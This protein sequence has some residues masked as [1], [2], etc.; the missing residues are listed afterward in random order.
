MDNQ[1]K[2][3]FGK[4]LVIKEDLKSGICYCQCKCGQYRSVP[5]AYLTAKVITSCGCSKARAIDLTGQRFGSLTAIQPVQMRDTDNSV[6]WLC[7]CSC[8]S[9]TTVSS[10]KLRTNHT[11]SCGCQ[12]LSLIKA[13]KTFIDGTCVEVLLSNKIR[14]NNTSGHTGVAKKGKKWQAYLTYGKKQHQLGVYASKEEAI[15]ARERA[16]HRVKEHLMTL[17]QSQAE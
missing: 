4:L 13:A 7:R 14:A 11:K 1:R 6:R 5:K 2:R 8:G 17:M 10:N 12:K 9:Y 15:Q 16:E 3:T